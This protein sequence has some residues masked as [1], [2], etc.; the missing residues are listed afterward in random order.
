MSDATIF[1]QDASIRGGAPSLIERF[2]IDNLH[3]YRRISLSSEFAATI[4]IARNGSGKTT[5][6]GVLDA[7]LRCQFSRLR[8][9]EFSEIFCK[10]REYHEE[11]RLTKD[12]VTQFSQIP[13]ES[14]L[15]QIARSGDLPIGSLFMFLTEEFDYLRNDVNA[16]HENDV[17][18]MILRQGSYRLRDAILIC[19]RLRLDLYRRNPNI[20]NIFEV[21][22]KALSDTEVVY[23]P[24]YRRIEL[25]MVVDQKEAI[26]RRRR[27]TQLRQ[28]AISLFRG[29]IQFGLADIS[30]RLSELNQKMLSDSNLGYR[31]ISANMINELIDGTYEREISM[32]KEI[33]DKNDLSLFFSRLQEGEVRYRQFGDISIPNIDRIYT[34]GAVSTESNNFL[35]YFLSKLN[36]V[37]KATRDIEFEVQEFVRNCN[38]YLSSEDHSVLSTMDNDVMVPGIYRDD[39]TLVLNR[40]N[41]RVHVEIQPGGRKVSLDALSSGEKQM[42]SLFAKLLLYP[43]RK[44]VLIDEP[45]LSLSI[46]W[47]RHILV[48]VVNSSQ[49]QQVIAITHSPFVFDNPL[50]PYAQSLQSRVSAN[51]SIPTSDNDQVDL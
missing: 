33:P 25:P 22:Q 28:S 51:P 43:K 1:T 20:Q 37:I 29:E 45:E 5:F 34:G 24:T 42:V 38:K 19:E 8:D 50:E 26:P 7:F 41:L 40:Q 44:I 47:Q 15:Y 12:D 17:F 32:M 3:G 35:R 2:G 9:L 36:N 49:C 6:L 31:R 13:A 11:L 4:L 23:L 46:E 18:S 27:P 14:E 30:E 16:L 48:D 10:L 21:L 39:K